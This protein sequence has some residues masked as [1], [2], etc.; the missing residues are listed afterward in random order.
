M[1][2]PSPTPDG[3]NIVINSNS[4]A[5]RSAGAARRRIGYSAS[6]TVNAVLLGA[7]LGWPGWEVI[8]FLSDEFRQVESWVIASIAVA[9]LV[10][11]IYLVTDPPVVKATGQLIADAVTLAAL[12]RIWRVFPFT[13]ADSTIPWETI[14]RVVIAVSVAATAIA[15]VDSAVRAVLGMIGGNGSEE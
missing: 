5:A 14:A 10:N 6:I 11:A 15:I 9:I 8:P 4:I 1:P 2:Q 13:F 12:I 7:I 3:V